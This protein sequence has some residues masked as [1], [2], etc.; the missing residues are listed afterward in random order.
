MPKALTVDK[1]RKEASNEEIPQKSSS[2][3]T[4]ITT[5]IGQDRA[6]KALQFGLGIDR[7]SVV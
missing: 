2:E 7:K 1:L 5:I 3:I 4:P 6:V